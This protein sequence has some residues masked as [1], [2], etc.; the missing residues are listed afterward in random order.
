M[1][2]LA[3]LL[4]AH[5][6]LQLEVALAG[7]VDGAVDLAVEAEHQR[8]GKF[9]YGVGRVG[10]DAHHLY[11]CF[12]GRLHV[13][14]VKARAAQGDK[15]D[16]VLPEQLDDVRVTFGVDEDAHHVLATGQFGRAGREAVLV[17]MYLVVSRL[18]LTVERVAVVVLC[19]EECYFNG[20]TRMFLYQFDNEYSGG[21]IPARARAY[22][23]PCLGVP[24]P[25]LRQACRPRPVSEPLRPGSHARGGGRWSHNRCCRPPPAG[26]CFCRS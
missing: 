21:R 6:A 3:I 1:S 12:A 23:R 20:H 13:H 16:A 19:V 22:L 4:E 26:R 2:S 8:D 25:V 5:Q 10:G 17:V 11:A 15:L 7:A 9:G 24:P 14:V 18:V